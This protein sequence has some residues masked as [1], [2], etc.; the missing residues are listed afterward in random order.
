MTA[1]PRFQLVLGDL[2]ADTATPAGGPSYFAVDRS[3]E[4]PADGLRVWLAQRG[5]VSPGDGA[6]L[7]LGDPDGLERVF[8]GTVAE[9]RPRAGGCE[10]F[11]V[12]TMLGLL[13]L[14]MSSLYVDQSA[15]DVAKDLIAQAGLDAG[16]VQDGVTLPRFAVDRALPA[17]PQL[18]ALA[19]RLGFDL[20]ADREGRIHF[21]GLGPAQRATRR[22]IY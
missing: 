3:L 9:V 17:F 14:R 8:T 1:I 5:S 20:F 12:G 15:G 13:E 11:A 21:R 10:V 4:V 22:W 19:D 18:R 7:E 2:A 16:E 6:V